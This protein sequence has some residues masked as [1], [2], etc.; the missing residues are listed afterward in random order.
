[1]NGKIL[2]ILLF[3]E[4]FFNL[5]TKNIKIDYYYYKDKF[6]CII[7]MSKIVSPYKNIKQHTRISLEPY[8]MNSDIRNTGERN[9]VSEQEIETMLKDIGEELMKIKPFET[10]F[11]LDSSPNYAPFNASVIS[12]PTTPP[13]SPL[14]TRFIS[15]KN[16]FIFSIG[17]VATIPPTAKTSKE[18]L[19]IQNYFLLP[20]R[21]LPK[22]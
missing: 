9:K 3:K 16:S 11:P 18:S 13:R 4:N 20:P 17:S 15:S 19:S 8:Y 10:T 7:I 6:Y 5:I 22:N 21:P 14:K 2:N 1:M 12:P